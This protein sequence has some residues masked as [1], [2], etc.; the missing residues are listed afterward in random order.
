MSSQNNVILLL[1]ILFTFYTDIYF[2][3]DQQTFSGVIMA[4]T[5]PL[6]LGSSD[7]LFAMA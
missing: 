1:L 5:L 2:P 7:F 6:K 3:E 4:G